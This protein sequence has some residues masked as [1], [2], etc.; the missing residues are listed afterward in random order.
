MCESWLKLMDDN[1]SLGATC[2]NT[3]QIQS[4]LVKNQPTPFHFA[5]RHRLCLHPTTSP[6]DYT[7][8]T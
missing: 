7:Y 4:S 2:I 5:Q 6:S 8:S 3:R 1:N